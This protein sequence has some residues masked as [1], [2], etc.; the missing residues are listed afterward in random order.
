MTTTCLDRPAASASAFRD[1]VRD[2]APL[3]AGFMPFGFVIGAAIAESAIDNVA[4]WAGAFLIAAGAAH[5]AVVEMADSGAAPVAII[6]TAVIINA[7][8]AVCSAGMAPWFSHEPAGRRRLLAY[9]LIDPTYLL[10]TARFRDDDPG[11][12]GRRR[13][14][15]GAATVLFTSWTAAVTVAVLVG[16]RVPEGF[17]LD[18]AAPL[19]LSGLLATSVSGRAARIAAGTGAL[20]VVAGAGLPWSTATLLAILVGSAAGARHVGRES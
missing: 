16:N 10:S 3:A 2:M 7:R 8:L 18:A 13:Y 1:G 9:F 5:L 4:G 6:A 17:R 11:C 19:I 20:I 15:L 12:D 14:Y